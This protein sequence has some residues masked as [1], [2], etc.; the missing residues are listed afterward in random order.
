MFTIKNY[1]RA[2]TLEQAYELNQKR[3]C[4]ILGGM[5][6]MKMSSAAFQTAVDLSGVVS[7]GIEEREDRFVIGAMTCLRELETSRCLNAYTGGAVRE[8]LRH[9]V[10]VQFRNLATVGGSIFGRFGFSDVLTMFLAMDT[11]VEL[12]KGGCIPLETF[13]AMP[14]DNDILINIIVKK[15]PLRTAYLSSRKTKTDFPV[16]TC[17]VSVLDGRLLAV[18]GARP[19]KAVRIWASEAVQTLADAGEKE[20]AARAFAEQIACEVKTGKNMRGTAEYRRHLAGVLT[21]RACLAA[22]DEGG[23]RAC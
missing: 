22:L 18:I 1:V 15:T 14:Y 11:E 10:G 20:A 17:A 2:E 23:V 4:R 16:L 19:Q 12:Y 13:A 6:W 5:L 3:S 8:S 21:K 7:A 9:I